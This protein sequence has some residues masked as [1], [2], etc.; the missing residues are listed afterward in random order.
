M[1]LNSTYSTNKY[2]NSKQLKLF[3]FGIQRQENNYLS[4]ISE[5]EKIDLTHNMMLD[6]VLTVY[7]YAKL[8]FNKYSSYY[9][10]KKYTQ[11]E[12]FAILTYTRRQYIKNHITI[13][14]KYMLIRHNNVLKGP[15]FDTVFAISAIKAIKSINHGTY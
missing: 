15:K 8:T 4:E 6:F 2:L 11:P 5:N 10:K 12:L 9:S 3:D 1:N 13:D 14:S 7:N